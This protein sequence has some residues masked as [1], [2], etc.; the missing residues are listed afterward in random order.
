[1]MIAIR[2]GQTRYGC[3]APFA[4]VRMVPSWSDDPVVPAQVFEAHVQWLPAAFSCGGP[5]LDSA[6]APPLAGV[7]CVDDQEWTV[8]FVE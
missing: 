8:F 2:D 7:F 4:E 1:M 6:R 3:T 5:A